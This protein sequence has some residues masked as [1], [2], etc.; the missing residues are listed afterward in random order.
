MCS[1]IL[2][3]FHSL[4]IKMYEDLNANLTKDDII[5]FDLT[6]TNYLRNEQI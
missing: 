1:L 4:L 6:K 3:L 5:V 2:L